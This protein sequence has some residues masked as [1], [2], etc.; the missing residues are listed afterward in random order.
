VKTSHLQLAIA[1]LALPLV[2]LHVA[3]KQHPDANEVGQLRN[4]FKRPGEWQGKLAPD[5]EL[6]LLDGSRFKLA[7]HVG[8][9]VVVLNFFATWCGPCK[10]EMPELDRFQ[11]QRHG[12]ALRLI[13]IDAEEK[14]DL[15]LAF[16]RDLPVPFPVGIDASGDLQKGFGVDSYPTTIVIGS[17]GRIQ[18]Y[19]AGAI[20]NAD[21]ALASLVD[22]NLRQIQGQK[23][24]SKDAYLASLKSERYPTPP[25]SAPTLGSRAQQIAESM[26]CPCGCSDTLRKCSCSTARKAKARLASLPLEGRHDADVKQ[27]LNREFCMKGME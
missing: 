18:L 12:Q 3:F 21:V 20:M 16:V 25:A 17:D 8:R 4:A 22:A 15:V 24:V 13:G 11:A 23:G 6:E 14:R 26:D 27:E 5:F 7:D 19:Q 2:G 1:M 9:E 10:A